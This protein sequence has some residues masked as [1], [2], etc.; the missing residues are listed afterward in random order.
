MQHT[1]SQTTAVQPSSHSEWYV[2]IGKQW[3]QLPELIPTSSNSGLC[4]SIQKRNL[5]E[6]SAGIQ[7]MSQKASFLVMVCWITLKHVVCL[8]KLWN[9]GGLLYWPSLSI[10]AKFGIWDYS[11]FCCLHLHVRFHFIYLLWQKSTYLTI[12]DVNIVLTVI[13]WLVLGSVR[14]FR[15]MSVHR[16]FAVNRLQ[17]VC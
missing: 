8:P 11:Q 16:F 4:G 7:P 3:Y 9:L 12:F 13:Y 6:R 2:L 5:E 17:L 15:P 10:S 14:H 1:G